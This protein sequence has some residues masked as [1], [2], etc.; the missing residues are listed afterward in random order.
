MKNNI[1]I[2]TDTLNLIRENDTLKKSLENSIQNQKIILESDV[3]T[4]KDIQTT[5]IQNTTKIITKHSSMNAA[6]A[7]AGRGHTAVLNFASPTH[8]GGLVLQGASSQEECLCRVSTL[9]KCLTDKV[10]CKT[11]PPAW[12]GDAKLR[13]A[14]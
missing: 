14:V 5:E 10:P 4:E 2:F 13:T 11:S 9:Y 8:A 12:V 6:R 1:E 3:Y 7:Y